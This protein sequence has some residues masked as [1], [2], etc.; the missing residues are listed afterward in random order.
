MGMRI[1][2]VFS[3]AAEDRGTGVTDRQYSKTIVS[4][5][6]IVDNYNVVTL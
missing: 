4:V 1:L 2:F 3:E 5:I 6:I